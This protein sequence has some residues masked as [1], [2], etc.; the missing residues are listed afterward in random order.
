MLE[1]SD[2]SVTFGGVRAVRHVSFAADA[3]EFVG[4]IG[5]NGSGKSTYLNALCGIVGATGKLSV[6][7][8][9]VRLGHP[10]ASRR[11]G[12]L[13]VFQAPQTFTNLTCLENVLLATSDRAHAGLT[14]AWFARRGMWHHEQDRFA[15][16]FTAL[17]RVGLA[18]SAELPASLLTYGQQRLLDLARAISAG[19]KVLL[20]DEPSAGLN[21]S[22]T[23]ELAAIVEGLAETGVTLVLVDHKVDFVDRICPRIVAMELGEKIADGTPHQVWS[24]PRVAD[25]YLGVDID[26][27]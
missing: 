14:G 5:P 4:L 20:L 16:A 17:D 12:V 9:P 2:I 11:A 25:A 18:A 15:I 13:R 8:S 3:G 24:D 23:G 27:A 26:D 1:T 22:E 7:G 19:P 10:R 6:D 21:D